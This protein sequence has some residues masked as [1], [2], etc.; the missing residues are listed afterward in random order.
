MPNLIDVD[1]LLVLWESYSQDRVLSAGALDLIEC[2]RLPVS[3]M[4]RK[5]YNTSSMHD[6]VQALE[7]S[8]NQSHNYYF[9]RSP[10]LALL[11]LQLISKQLITN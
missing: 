10:R 6:I 11:R 7:Q 4:S 1:A 8:H 5:G 3:L 9:P 2:T